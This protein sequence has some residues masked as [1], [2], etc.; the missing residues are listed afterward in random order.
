METILVRNQHIFHLPRPARLIQYLKA[1]IYPPKIEAET[2]CQ[3]L[4]YYGLE[5]TKPPQNLPFGRRN[6]LAVVYTT[7]GKKVLKLHKNRWKVSTILYEHSILTQLESI[8]FSAPRLVRTLN[9]ETLVKIGTQNFTLFNYV[10]GTSFTSTF[11]PWAHRQKLHA[12]AGKTLAEF[13]KLLEGFLPQGQH[14]LGYKSYS[15]ERWRDLDW[16]IN[17]LSNLPEKLRDWKNTEDKAHIDWFIEHRHHIQ[18]WLCQLHE[19]LTEISLPRL[20]IHGD[21]GI[22]NLQ[23]HRDRT[24]T[25]HDFELARLE[26]R[27]TDLV[28]VLSRF[29]FDRSQPF[30]AA[31]QTE[32]P[33][34][35]EEWHFLPQVWQ[36]Y[37]LQGAIQY[38][39]TF[40]EI[41]GAHRLASARKRFNQ[42]DW[43]AAH[44]AQLLRLRN[45]PEGIT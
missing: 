34:S 40:C 17:I 25:V 15:E 1:R 12:I 22:H 23:F 42:A 14:H 31:Y 20:V 43:A 13:H 26:W 35:K 36:F 24:V 11:M 2:V 18:D 5:L 3:V 16:H 27:L 9:N 45:V 44:K 8:G 4:K 39:N 19:N 30:M 33:L 32:Y 29:E 41:G 6:R 28:T 37:K 7:A 10:E 38:W 21:Y